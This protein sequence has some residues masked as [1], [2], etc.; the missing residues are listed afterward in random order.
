MA[1]VWETSPALTASTHDQAA[2][3]HVK[4][5]HYSITLRGDWAS[6]PGADS[7]QQTFYS[8]RLDTTVVMSSLAM[9]ASRG[10]LERIAHVLADLR[11]RAEAKAAVAYGIETTIAEPLVLP[12]PWGYV[13]AYYGSDSKGRHFAYTGI[14]IKSAVISVYADSP[15]ASERALAATM[16]RLMNDLEFDR[17]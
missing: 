5:P 6:R 3:Q 7:E 16:S 8:R 11:V 17:S 4:D 15:T 9:D 14:I 1:G 10:E 13:I 12:R 2:I